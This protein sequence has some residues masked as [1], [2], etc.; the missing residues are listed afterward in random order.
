MGLS[1]DFSASTAALLL[2][3]KYSKYS[4]YS[5]DGYNLIVKEIFAKSSPHVVHFVSSS[6]AIRLLKLCNSS[7]QVVRVSS[8]Y[9]V[10][11]PQVMHSR[12]LKLFSQSPLLCTCLLLLCSQSPLLVQPI[13]LCLLLLC[14]PIDPASSRYVSSRYA[15]IQIRPYCFSTGNRY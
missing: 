13:R 3:S 1:K 4:K 12:L 9:P 5:S 11:S 2:L 14:S 10:L 7:P 8:S 6:C 15:V